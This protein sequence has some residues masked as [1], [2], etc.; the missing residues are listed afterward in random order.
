M[1]KSLLIATLIFTCIKAQAYPYDE[2][3]IKFLKGLFTHH[4]CQILSEYIR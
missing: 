4:F 1:K 3:I 2:G